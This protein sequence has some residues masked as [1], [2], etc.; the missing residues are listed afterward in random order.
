MEGRFINPKKTQVFKLKKWKM[1]K[2]INSQK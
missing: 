2:T 1:K